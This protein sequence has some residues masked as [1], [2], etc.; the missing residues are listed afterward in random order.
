M[1]L[2]LELVGKPSSSI[3]KQ[4]VQ[5]SCSPTKVSPEQQSQK[6]N[7]LTFSLGTSK[8][9]VQA[10]PKGQSPQPRLRAAQPSSTRALA[11]LTASRISIAPEDLQLQQPVKGIQQPPLADNQ[12]KA[13]LLIGGAGASFKRG[14]GVMSSG[15]LN[16]SIQFDLFKPFSSATQL[17]VGSRPHVFAPMSRASPT[18]PTADGTGHG[19]APPK[20]ALHFQDAS[21][22]PEHGLRPST[23]TATAPRWADVRTP[24]TAHGGP[25][26]HERALGL[27]PKTPSPGM[28][29]APRTPFEGGAQS[30]R[31]ATPAKD[32]NQSL[33]ELEIKVYGN[34]S[35]K[36]RIASPEKVLK[37][38][39]TAVCD[40]PGQEQHYVD[41]SKRAAGVYTVGGWTRREQHPGSASTGLQEQPRLPSNREH[42]FFPATTTADQARVTTKE[43]ATPNGFRDHVQFVSPKKEQGLNNGVGTSSVVSVTNN[44]KNAPSGVP[45]SG[46]GTPATVVDSRFAKYHA[47]PAHSPMPVADATISAGEPSLPLSLNFA[48]SIPQGSK[49]P[50]TKMTAMRSETDWGKSLALAASPMTQ[51]SPFRQRYAELQMYLKY[52]DEVR[53]EHLVEGIVRCSFHGPTF[54]EPASYRQ[55]NSWDA[56]SMSLMTS[57]Q[58]VMANL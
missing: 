25:Q 26:W 58:L 56:C 46:A 28:L 19:P 22:Q 17:N 42:M 36:R 51:D 52:C 55:L 6:E 39:R 50:P 27:T 2:P 23:S 3:V 47:V 15:A 49:A 44:F 1:P 43:K 34:L 30:L 5:Q 4:A 14:L 16:G 24:G 38:H 40:S 37:A 13:A 45:Q 53:H 9:P 41:D 31:T 33:E 48:H 54:H 35:R 20:F 32:C 7:L 12:R 10:T 8:P 29:L 57:T 21:L 18:T 11:T